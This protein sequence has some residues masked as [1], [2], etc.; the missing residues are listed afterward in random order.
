MSEQQMTDRE[1]LIHIDTEVTGLKEQFSN[2][3]KHHW[4]ATIALI[5]IT[6]TAITAVIIALLTK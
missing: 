6:G 2:H 3:L 4:M 5:S 1:Y